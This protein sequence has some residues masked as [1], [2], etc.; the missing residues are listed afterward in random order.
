M[1]GEGEAL[2]QGKGPGWRGREVKRSG[3]KR[4]GCR[5]SRAGT[6]RPCLGAQRVAGNRGRASR[7]DGR[8]HARPFSD[9]DLTPTGRR[10]VRKFKETKKQF[11]KVREDMELSL[12]RNA[13]APRHRP[14]EVE[15]ATGALTLTRKCFR[16]LALDYVLQVSHW[17]WSGRVPEAGG[18]CSCVPADRWSW[19]L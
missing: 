9:S 2:S 3:D 16:H 12:V 18:S 11:D 7:A 10:D 6:G 17:A 15:E 5:G 14:H 13:Q 8:P 19:H 4:D 1:E